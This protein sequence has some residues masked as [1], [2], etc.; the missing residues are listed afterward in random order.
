MFLE[1]THPTQRSTL[2]ITNTNRLYHSCYYLSQLQLI[3]NAEI[4]Q[5]SIQR[6]AVKAAVNELEWFCKQLNDWLEENEPI[7]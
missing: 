6:L 1:F 2:L 5:D 3:E 4:S 7:E